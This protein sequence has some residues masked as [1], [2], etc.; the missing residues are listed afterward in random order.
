MCQRP[1]SFGVRIGMQIGEMV[2]V[3]D[4]LHKFCVTTPVE[5]L[6][7]RENAMEALTSRSCLACDDASWLWI[8]CQWVDHASP[9]TCG[10]D[11][12]RFGNS[13]S[14][15]PYVIKHIFIRSCPVEASKNMWRNP[16]GQ[17]I[18]NCMVTTWVHY[19]KTCKKMRRNLEQLQQITTA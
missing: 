2:L 4:E 13:T 6:M 3:T 9:M 11:E 17:I 15:V 16:N 18:C 14:G 8:Q 10:S 5:F 1:H 12:R 7:I 19:F